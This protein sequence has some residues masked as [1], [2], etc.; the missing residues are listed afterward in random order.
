MNVIVNNAAAAGKILK[1]GNLARRTVMLPLDKISG[2]TIN[3][4]VL[5]SAQRIVGTDNV[6]RALDLITYEKSLSR[7]MEHIFG[8]SLVVRNLDQANKLAYHKDVSKVCVTLD[9]DVVKPSG[10]MSGGAASKGGSTLVQQANSLK[11]LHQ[12]YKRLKTVYDK[13]ES[14]L[15]MIK[16]RLA[17][18]KH[19]QLTEEFSE[20]TANCEELE[21][22]ISES[23]KVENESS[24][25]V[26]DIEYKIKNAK[27]IKEKELKETEKEVK[28][29]KKA[30]AEAKAKWSEKESEDASIKL[31]ISELEK[32]IKSAEEQ[33]AATE[34]AIVQLEKQHAESMGSVDDMKLLV[35][36]AKEAVKAQ[37][38]SLSSNNKE[39]NAEKSKE[40]QILKTNTER[41][42]EIQQLKHK[43]S[44]ATEEARDAERTVRTML[45]KYEWISDDRQFFGKA[46]TAYDFASTDPKEAGRK[47]Q[48]L[49]ETKEK[50]SKTVNMR[51][52]KM[53]GKAEEQFNDLMRKKTTVETDKAKIYK[54]IEELDIKKKEELRKAWGIVNDSFGKIFSALLPGAKAKLQPPEGQDVLDGLEVRIGFGD[55]WKESLSELSGGQRSLVALSLILSLLKF[56][57]A[58]LYIL[59][60]VDAALDLSHTQ[61]IGNM[62]KNIS[63]ILR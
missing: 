46:N 26:K 44:K 3:D 30:E 21:S 18:T 41:E 28:A 29:C 50:L 54:V 17:Q 37:K 57:P 8:G 33:L 62:L 15:K 36:E 48:K 27:S 59:D 31:E 24:T 47:I 42:L 6:F 9:G 52:M 49:E 11:G 5:R 40:E 61:N 53:L 63:R 7:A 56:N 20:L 38:N 2:Y 25:A 13:K 14:E 60:E 58:P 4:N 10:D 43:I 23:R 12:E 1:H 32:S 51:A 35:Q 22:R 39:I 16:S 45:E 34:E 55:V 19:H